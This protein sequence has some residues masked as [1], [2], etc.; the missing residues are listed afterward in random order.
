MWFIRSNLIL[1]LNYKSYHGWNSLFK[2]MFFTS[3]V[4]EHYKAD[5]TL[6]FYRSGNSRTR[7]WGNCPWSHTLVSSMAYLTPH[8]QYQTY[9]TESFRQTSQIKNSETC[10][11]RVKKISTDISPTIFSCV[12]FPILREGIYSKSWNLND[13]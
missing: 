2:C 12:S 11:L 7:S 1:S 9:S 6:L 4:P 13:Y 5:L 8:S 3:S 10:P